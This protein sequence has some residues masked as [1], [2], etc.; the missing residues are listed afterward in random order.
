MTVKIGNTIC[1]NSKLDY[2]IAQPFYL[3]Y[4]VLMLKLIDAKRGKQYRVLEVHNVSKREMNRIIDWYA[5][6]SGS[7]VEKTKNSIKVN[8][9]YLCID[10]EVQK[11]IFVTEIEK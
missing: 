4:G 10:N 3:S 7:I 1:L 6:K 8:G 9:V 11:R 2:R 5:L